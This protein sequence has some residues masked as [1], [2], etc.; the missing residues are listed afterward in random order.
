MTTVSVDQSAF[1]V[2]PGFS[3]SPPNPPVTSLQAASL[4]PDLSPLQIPSFN[5]SSAIFSVGNS[6]FTAVNIG[7][8]NGA[9]IATGLVSGSDPSD[10]FRF[11]TSAFSSFNLRLTGTGTGDADIFLI[12]DINNNGFIDFG[13]GEIVAS[14][15]TN[16]N[17]EFFSVNGLLPGTYYALVSHFSGGTTNYTLSLSTDTAGSDFLSARNLGT[18][19]TPGTVSDFVGDADPSDLYRFNLSN[20]SDIN[21]TLNGLSSDADLYLIQDLNQNG[22]LDSAD[23]LERSINFSNASESISVQGLTAGS[24]FIEVAQYSGDTNYTLNYSAAPSDAG[25]TLSTASN[26]G[27]LTGRRVVNGSVSSTDL[28]DIYRF[29]TDAVSD[30]KLTLSGLSA[31]ADL[32]LIQDKNNNGLI[33]AGETL[34]YSVLSGASSESI[35]LSG[36]AVGNYFVAV[37]RYSG[38]TNYTLTLE[39][40]S[41]GKSLITA[42]NIGTLTGT[43]TI[44]DFIS[45]QDGT[46]YYRFNV[47]T[48][49]S[50]TL[51]LDGMTADGDLYLIRDINNNGLV[52][53]NEIIAVSATDGTSSET[54]FNDLT[55]GTYYVR[56]NQYSG[57]TNYKLNLSMVAMRPE[58]GNTLTAATNL[59]T[60]SG[61]RSWSDSLSLNDVD[62]LYRF[63]LNTTSDLQLTLTG[64]TSNADLFL[65]RDANN[66]GVVD[67]GDVLQSS[68]LIGAGSE[69][70]SL[71]GL[72]AGNY[73]VG[74]RG[75]GN[76][77]NYTLN[78][79]AD[80]A[81]ETL[82]TA[83]NIGALTGSRSFTDFLSLQD[84]SDFYRFSLNTTSNVSIN[85]PGLTADFDLYLVRDT[86]GNGLVDAGE[87]LAISATDGSNSPESIN[88]NNLASGIYY[89]QVR[90]FSGEANYTLN[91][92]TTPVS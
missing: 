55:A 78:L 24:Y 39:A 57:N 66:N 13:L 81:G 8:L 62:D 35:N 3:E 40:D 88:I 65:I 90:Q 5:G 17:S 60:L 27:T 14:S 18:L 74:V 67:S 76:T 54:I 91:L 20:T 52:E 58:P 34:E 89:V 92:T 49:G 4:S 30:V 48:A 38:N 37:D 31:D 53:T 11:T 2:L 10:Y 72:T 22:I 41:A 16:G 61:Q 23:V 21:L 51:R 73:F 9:A 77:T 50:L 19:T 36:L 7:A 28:I 71:A 64:L 46:D 68:T 43:R 85:L 63:S 26:L 29:N 1:A 32:Y 45:E 69:F 86:N 80:A 6:M 59:G 79:T 25:N 47:T 75:Y 42:R 44:N 83:R 12:Q 82:A 70:I 56:V 87:T 33:D 15:S 84:D